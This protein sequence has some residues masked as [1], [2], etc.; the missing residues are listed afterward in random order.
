M[1]CVFLCAL[2]VL[3]RNADA[4]PS[5]RQSCATQQNGARAAGFRENEPAAE[6]AEA[7]GEG[8]QCADLLKRLANEA[9][10]GDLARHGCRRRTKR[11]PIGRRFVTST[12][13]VKSALDKSQCICGENRVSPCWRSNDLG[14]EFHQAPAHV[15]QSR[16]LFGRLR[17]SGEETL[18]L[19]CLAQPGEDVTAHSENAGICSLQ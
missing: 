15:S 7:Q 19:L 17:F 18:L 4:V 1:V 10:H 5:Q 13:P 12:R 14:G 3:G 6:S 11:L 2:L 9:M 16:F 8:A